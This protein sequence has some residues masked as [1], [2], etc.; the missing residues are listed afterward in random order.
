MGKF[1]KPFIPRPGIL[2]PKPGDPLGYCT[3]DG[4]WAAVPFGKKFIII[5]NGRQDKVC[6]TYKQSVDY[7]KKQVKVHK[8]KTSSLEEFL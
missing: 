5:H 2:N 8:K 1:Q 7:I 6:N 4:M 3:N